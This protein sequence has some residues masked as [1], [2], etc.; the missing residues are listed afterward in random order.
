VYIY[1]YI[2]IYKYTVGYNYKNL[3]QY[4]GHRGRSQ[5]KGILKW[6]MKAAS[7]LKGKGEEGR[8]EE[9][10]GE[11]SWGEEGEIRG[12]ERGR[13]SNIEFPTPNHFQP[14]GLWPVKT[15]FGENKK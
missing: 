4:A 5:G 8:W 14:G 9:G 2:Y 7:P 6:K 10:R 1:V 11:K 3:C 13:V 15:I 12:E